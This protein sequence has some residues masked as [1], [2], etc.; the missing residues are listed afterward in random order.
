MSYNTPQ[1]TAEL[2]VES[3][4]AKAAYPVG[5]ALVGGFL[6]GAYIAFGG[7]LA[8]VASAGLNSATWGGIVTLVTG[9]TFSL[10]L[11]LTIVGG[12][13][14]LTGNMMLV[15]ISVLSRR[16]KL[17]RLGFNWAFVFVGNFIGSLF[18]AYVLAD[19]TGV[20]GTA[21]SKAGTGPAS[22]YARLA[23]L[24]ISKAVGE[25]NLEVFLRAIGCNWLVCLG[26]WL[27]LA[28]TDVAGKILGIVLPITAFVALGFDHVVAN[29]FFLPLAMFQHV[30]GVT[31]THVVTNLIFALLGNMVGAGLFV[32]GAYWYLYLNVHKPQPGP[33]GPGTIRDR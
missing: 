2:A 15:P 32:A 22:N 25:S 18:V 7:L 19:K 24:T 21:A 11:V 23:A 16:T 6:A 20:I 28:S 10:G 13:E 4:T 3:G 9:L 29:M 26:V 1:Q 27:A 8:I 30:P 31:I 17:G 14:L 33:G 5:K 12:A